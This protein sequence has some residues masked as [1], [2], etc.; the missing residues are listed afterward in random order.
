[1]SAVD[2][3][4]APCAGV[5]WIMGALLVAVGCSCGSDEPVANRPDSAQGTPKDSGLTD[6]RDASS[7]SS[8]PVV[9]ARVVLPIED[10]A[11]AGDAAVGPGTPPATRD[12]AVADAGTRKICGGI[13]GIACKD[14]EFC[15][16]EDATSGVG[17]GFPDSTGVCT[18]RPGP[19]C[20]T[21]YAPV[22][23]C[24][25]KTYSNECGAHSAGVS[26]AKQGECTTG[27]GV[28][29]DDRPGKVTCKKTRPMCPEFQ[30]PAVDGSCW[31][32][33]VAIDQCVC[34]QADECPERDTYVCH[35]SAGH[36][37]PFVN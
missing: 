8:A 20:N 11:V 14:D 36:C 15:S 34:K 30:V 9:D 27:L 23:G 25:N 35:M 24:D 7:G 33:C 1:M 16:Q 29:C 28:S 12:A 22:C 10:P 13:A 37:G 6:R 21:L 26:I 4:S 3:P 19:G 31:G 18:R 17:C 32:D 2:L 5:S